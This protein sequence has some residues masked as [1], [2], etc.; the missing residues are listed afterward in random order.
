MTWFDNKLRINRESGSYPR[1]KKDKENLGKYNSRASNSRKAGKNSNNNLHKQYHMVKEEISQFLCDLSKITSVTYDKMKMYVLA[2]IQELLEVVQIHTR[3]KV[4]T[5]GQGFEFLVKFITIIEQYH[6]IKLGKDESKQNPEKIRAL[7]FNKMLEEKLISANH[8]RNLVVHELYNLTNREKIKIRSTYFLCLLSFLEEEFK[9][10]IDFI[11][12]KLISNPEDY[13]NLLAEVKFL[14]YNCFV[15]DFPEN[16]R[17]NAEISAILD[18]V[19][20]LFNEL[21]YE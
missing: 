4:L 20:L 5:C 9:L 3:V 17:Y 1:S 16:V 12:E 18:K 11:K 7:K 10:F 8:L 19:F 14:L 21:K 15:K 2:M 6:N 13:Y